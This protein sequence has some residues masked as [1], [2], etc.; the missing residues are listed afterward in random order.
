LNT[1]LANIKAERA[2]PIDIVTKKIGI[3]NTVAKSKFLSL[4]TANDIINAII[5]MVAPTNSI[6]NIVS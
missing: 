5:L 4:L 1:G 3:N 6:L 2:R